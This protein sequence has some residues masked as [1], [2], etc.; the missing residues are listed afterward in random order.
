MK[1]F[2]V[3][4]ED[5]AMTETVEAPSVQRAAQKVTGVKKRFDL[6]P[7][8]HNQTGQAALVP[9]IMATRCNGPRCVVFP[10]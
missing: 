8:N 1:S 2:L 4:Y 3:Y 10:L 5:A 6:Q 9:G 7:I